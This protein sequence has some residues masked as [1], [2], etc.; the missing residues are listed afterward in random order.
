MKDRRCR[1]VSKR[2]CLQAHIRKGSAARLI[3][4]WSSQTASGVLGDATK[5]T[6]EKGEKFLEAA[7]EGLIELIRELRGTEIPPRRDQHEDHIS[8]KTAWT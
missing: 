1:R 2:I 6:V 5:A 7:T 4:Y 8:R 3:P